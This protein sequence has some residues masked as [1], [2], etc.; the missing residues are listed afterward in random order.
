MSPC[1]S[2]SSWTCE[3]LAKTIGMNHH[4]LLH[5]FSALSSQHEAADPQPTCLHLS[6][7]A[8]SQQELHI[9]Q[10]ESAVDGWV[11]ASDTTSVVFLNREDK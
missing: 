5:V 7:S 10:G 1:S 6:I 4:G 11:N 3:P 2:G 9:E 8:Y